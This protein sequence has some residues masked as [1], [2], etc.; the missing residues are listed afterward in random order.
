[1]T[2][3]T[4]L[5]SALS[6]ESAFDLA[7]DFLVAIAQAIL[8]RMDDSLFSDFSVQ[9]D[10][11]L[12]DSVW[13]KWN[14]AANAAQKRQTLEIIARS[15]FSEFDE[16]LER[17]EKTLGCSANSDL[18]QL[19]GNYLHLLPGCIRQ[20]CKR[21]S[22]PAGTVIPPGLKLEGWSDLLPLLPARMTRFQ[23]GDRPWAV[24]EW[25]LEELIEQGPH[26]EVWKARNLKDETAPPVALHFF[27][28]SSAR[29]YV[30]KS[31]AGALRQVQQLGD[32]TGL[33]RLQEI[34]DLSDPPCL[35]Y[36]YVDAAPMPALMQE[37]KER[38]LTPDAW[39]V[40]ELIRQL[41]GL[42]GQLHTR[43]PALVHRHLRPKHILF[44]AKAS[45]GWVCKLANLGLGP[46]AAHG[47]DDSADGNPYVSPEQFRGDDPRPQDDVYALGVLWHQLLIGDLTR[48]R[49]GGA[50]WRRRLGRLHVPPE[51]IGLLECC[52]DDD[53]G[54]RPADGL[55]LAKRISNLTSRSKA[56][57]PR[58]T[59]PGIRVPLVNSIGMPIVSLR[60][61]TFWMG[62][63]IDEPGRCAQEYLR[64]ETTLTAP[65]HLSATPVTVAQFER[66]LGRNPAPGSRADHPVTQVSWQ[67]AEAFC[68]ALSALPEEQNAGRMYRLPTEAEWEYA[69]RAGTG[70]PYGYGPF[71]PPHQACFASAA[72][73]PVGSYAPNGF[74]LYDM[75]GAVWEWC[76]DVCS[77]NPAGALRP[78]R[79]GS[80]RTDAAACRA[81]SRLVLPATARADDAGF[82]VV[83][84]Q[85]K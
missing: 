38:G 43:T 67:D 29:S 39:H 32:V 83:M 36:A 58:P 15:S 23:P 77:G 22:Q 46:W 3:S 47:G 2:V 73:P 55:D 75:H 69:C 18:G 76:A 5:P 17:V 79:G 80:W 49:P 65:F 20:A 72:P 48:P 84:E 51:I 57:P 50:S 19:L 45:G 68:Q 41:A 53:L 54:E 56:S 14:R 42:L 37:W 13:T 4:V 82:R 11:E 16:L 59:A 35:Q 64:H 30:Q 81:A 34:H 1:M 25:E 40:A 6:K 12:A 21:P 61:G 28:H 70:G 7:E 8:D 27:H 66:V 71:L 62:S 31:G 52:F 63:A 74:G 60:A 10:A 24:G 26:G 33:L 78:L 44:K 85:V 9:G